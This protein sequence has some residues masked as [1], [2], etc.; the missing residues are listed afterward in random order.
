MDG[1]KSS[2][3]ASVHRLQ[4][5]VTALIANLAH[6]DPVR[7]MPESSGQELTR[8]DGN[9][10]GNRFDRLPANGIGMGYLQ[11]GWLLNHDEPFV[12]GNVI[13]QRLH[14]SCFARSGPTADDPVLLLVDKA[15]NRVPNVRRQAA[16]G[17]QLVRGIPAIEFADRHGDAVDG[18]RWSHNGN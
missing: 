18:G 10:A 1:R 13:E 12:M 11:F 6:D 15:N 4:Q 8:S 14:Q 7:T 17:N 9:L 2:A 16:G 5:V 3:V